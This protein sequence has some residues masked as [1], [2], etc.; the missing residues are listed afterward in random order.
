MARLLSVS[1]GLL[2]LGVFWLGLRRVWGAKVADWGTLFLGLAP[3]FV[4]YNRLALQERPRCSG[5]SCRGH[6]GPTD[7]RAKY[8]ERGF[9]FW[10]ARLGL[11]V[12]FKS[13][14]RLVL[15]AFAVGGGPLRLAEARHLPLRERFLSGPP[16]I[17]DGWGDLSA[18]CVVLVR[19]APCSVSP[20]GDFYRVHEIQPHSWG[21][22]LL[23]VRRGLIG[24]ERG[25][26][27]S[28][29]PDARAVPAGGVRGG[30]P[31]DSP[32]IGGGGG[33]VY[34]RSGC[35]AASPSACCRPM[36]RAATTSCSCRRW[37]DWP[38]WAWPG[39]ARR[40]RSPPLA[41]FLL[42][43]GLWYAQPGTARRRPA[44]PPEARTHSAAGE[45]VLGEFAPALCLDTMF[46]A[47]PVQ[48]GLS[49]DDRPVE[50]LHAN[51][52]CVTRPP[53][54]TLVAV[55][56][57]GI[58]QP[59]HWVA[60]FVLGGSRHEVV[61]VY[62]VNRGRVE[63]LKTVARYLLSI[64]NDLHG[65]RALRSPE[66]FIASSRTGC[67]RTGRWCYQRVL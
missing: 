64:A 58:V 17:G 29:G 5:L 40:C 56:L 9:L 32:R 48:P 30:G 55:A 49:N 18:L 35:S 63:I 59:S 33:E 57:P 4:F 3:P 37:L 50:R 26:S 47:A 66:P 52:V 28:A 6:S 20:Y 11:A 16:I 13:L 51:Y 65:Y 39:C 36:R 42:T 14:A 25:V 62:A 22:V 43:S 54:G 1:F 53:L 24:G 19:A 27:V 8:G 12:I 38:R 67:R 61:D 7:A 45:R 15:P 23:N 46:A 44:E 21:S 41:L 31:L 60:S 10:P 34:S 2:T